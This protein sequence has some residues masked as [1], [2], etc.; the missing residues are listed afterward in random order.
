MKLTEHTQLL[1]K[2]NFQKLPH[3]GHGCKVQASTPALQ[4]KVNK[5]RNAE[6][7]EFSQ[8]KKNCDIITC[9]FPPTQPQAVHLPP[10]TSRLHPT[11]AWPTLLL[12]LFLCSQ[13]SHLKIDT[14]GS[15][16]L[17][18]GLSSKPVCPSCDIHRQRWGESAALAHSSLRLQE[19]VVM[20]S[21]RQQLVHP[22]D[23]TG[24]LVLVFCF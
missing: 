1:H 15:C 21:R 20:T 14:E 5:R 2:P 3:T 24:V 18:L 19:E 4:F 11:R 7:L 6:S 12:C 9:P 22:R 10:S 16:T 13:N 23:W 17:A 8:H